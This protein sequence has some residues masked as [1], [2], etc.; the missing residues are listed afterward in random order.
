M[1]GGEAAAADAPR[2]M[3]AV[4]CSKPVGPST[5]SFSPK[6]ALWTHGEHNTRSCALS[7]VHRSAGLMPPDRRRTAVHPQIA[8]MAQIRPGWAKAS[9]RRWGQIGLTRPIA[10]ASPF[11]SRAERLAADPLPSLA[12]APLN[13]V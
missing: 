3:P 8:Q 12:S 7:Q 9:T 4:V 13:S 1:E 5:K 10:W 6:P 2:L 11:L